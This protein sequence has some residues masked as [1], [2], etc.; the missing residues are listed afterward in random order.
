MYRWLNRQFVSNLAKLTWEQVFQ[1]EVMTRA[2]AI[3]FSSMMAAVPLLVL[4]GFICVHLLPDLTGSGV[5]GIGNLTAEQLHASLRAFFPDMVYQVVAQELAHMQSHPP[6]AVLSFTVPLAVW[7]SSSAFADI[8]D[9]INRIYGVT[10]TRSF[11]RRRI[12][13]IVMALVQSVILFACITVVLVWPHFVEWLN[14]SSTHSLLITC[15]KWVALFSVLL[16]SYALTFWVGPDAPQRH[17]WVTPGAAFGAIVFLLASWLFRFYIQNWA[18]YDAWYGSLGGVMAVMFWFWII[19][20]V[21][22][23]A[24]QMNRLVADGADAVVKARLQTEESA[25]PDI[26]KIIDELIAAEPDKVAQAQVNPAL[27]GWFVGQ[28]MKATDGKADAAAVEQ[29]LKRK[30][31]SEK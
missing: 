20:M 7:T 23:V 18:N 14:L 28:V 27:I 1:H 6:A 13:A 25:M 3:A 21:L 9:A 12:T 30:F 15:I 19:S 16:G 22:L 31:A 2:S 5:R 17:Q 4:A 26:E 8:I 11:L 24:A 29:T 10:E